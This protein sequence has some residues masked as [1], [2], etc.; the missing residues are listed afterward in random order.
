MPQINCSGRLLATSTGG[1]FKQKVVS[2]S[3]ADD[4]VSVN[5]APALLAMLP[6]AVV[7]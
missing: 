1:S 3:V 4:D 6:L 7:I 2:V 5:R